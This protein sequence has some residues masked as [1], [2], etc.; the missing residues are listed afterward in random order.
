MT[1]VQLLSDSGSFAVLANIKIP[2]AVKCLIILVP[3]HFDV[4][5][6]DAA[7]DKLRVTFDHT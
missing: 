7:D 6:V 5:R 2:F 1:A 3:R 4:T